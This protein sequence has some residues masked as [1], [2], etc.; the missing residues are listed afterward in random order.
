MV[1]PAYFVFIATI[2][3]ELVF[4]DPGMV[5]KILWNKYCLTSVIG[6]RDIYNQDY[7][8]YVCMSRKFFHQGGFLD[9]L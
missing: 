7:S 8:L 1:V 2:I 4:V 6:N 3:V 5:F 9:Y